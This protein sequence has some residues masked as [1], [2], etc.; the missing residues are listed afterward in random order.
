M[1]NKVVVISIG[2]VIVSSI[3]I[4]YFSNSPLDAPNSKVVSSELDSQSSKDDSNSS[5]IQPSNTAKNINDFAN[6]NKQQPHIDSDSNKI[7][8][9]VK[10]A[11]GMNNEK[12]E[13]QLKSSSG[14][15][16]SMKNNAELEK[17]IEKSDEFYK[18]YVSEF[19]DYNPQEPSLEN[20]HPKPEG[21]YA[22]Q[23]DQ[24][25]IYTQAKSDGYEWTIP[26][27]ATIRPTDKDIAKPT[28]GELSV[29]INQKEIVD[30]AITDGYLPQEVEPNSH[31]PVEKNAAISAVG[32]NADQ[33][34]L[35]DG[36][37]SSSNNSN[38]SKDTK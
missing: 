34:N 38:S 8:S 16:A 23:I 30:K 37:L 7:A 10:F 17:I 13:S 18:Q 1:N 11:S 6:D 15:I 9:R 22:A 12:N 19:S 36:N 33:V 32:S 27:S 28:T 14:D 31:P 5:I 29:E 25:S 3:S 24:Q 20:V 26:G 35:P 4:F 21:E 2:I